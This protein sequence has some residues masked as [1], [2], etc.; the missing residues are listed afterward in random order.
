[1]S[2]PR[3]GSRAKARAVQ[4]GASRVGILEANS[5]LGELRGDV[6]PWGLWR[7]DAWVAWGARRPPAVYR[8]PGNSRHRGLVPAKRVGSQ[9]LVFYPTLAALQ[10][11]TS[12]LKRLLDAFAL[13]AEALADLLDLG[14]L[15]IG[16]R[17]QLGRLLLVESLEPRRL[18]LL[19]EHLALLL[20]RLE[21][22]VEFLPKGLELRLEGSRLRLILLTKRSDLLVYCLDLSLSRIVRGL[23]R[24]SFGGSTH[25]HRV[26]ERRDHFHARVES[27]RQHQ[28]LQGAACDTVPHH[29][30][31]SFRLSRIARS[32]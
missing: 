3:D 15:L 28:G 21:L 16:Q 19:H 26:R 25:R 23:R 20:E 2:R 7:S 12:L 10:I 9:T 1:D 4:G 5:F 8:G 31:F 11:V 17:G 22:G 24:G 13:F 27:Q 14:S 29:S 18:A 6:P 32:S 30:R